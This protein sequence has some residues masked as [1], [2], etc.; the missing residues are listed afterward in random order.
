MACR[1]LN[2]PQI[3]IVEC[4][5]DVEQTI[6]LVHNL[7]SCQRR[8]VIND[9]LLGFG[10]IRFLGNTGNIEWV[11][12]SGIGGADEGEE[13]NIWGCWVGQNTKLG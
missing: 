3:F 6:N 1:A 8:R 10:C 2:F 12:R 5:Y 11:G 13:Y 9:F 7:S 4:G